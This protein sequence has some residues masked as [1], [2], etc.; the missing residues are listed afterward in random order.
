MGGKITLAQPKTGFRAGLD[1]VLLGASV[2][3][4]SRT[5]LELGSGVGAAALTALTHRPELCALLVERNPDLLTLAH[6]NIEH[7][8]FANRAG[9]LLLDVTAEGKQRTKAGLKTDHFS[10]IIANPPYFDAGGGTQ[11]PEKARAAA[12]HMHAEDLDKWVR[13]A[14]ASAAP[15]GEVIFIFR[16]DGLAELLDAFTRRFGAITLLPIVPRTGEDA[17]RVLM[18]GIKGSRAPMVLKSPLVLHGAEGRTFLPQVDAI[19]RGKDVL[20]W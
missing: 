10:T 12:R 2:A 3:A 5:L 17:N 9:T 13:T 11:A 6:Q 16:A 1:S 19:F 8:D 4:N 15:R 14:A 18:R 20:H 7:N